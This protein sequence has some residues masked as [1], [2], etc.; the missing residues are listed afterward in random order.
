[1]DELSRPKQLVPLGAIKHRTHQTLLALFDRAEPTPP[2]S[3]FPND[4]VARMFRQ[5]AVHDRRHLIAVYE[6]CDQAGLAPETCLAG[7]LHDIGKASLAGRNVSVIDRVRHVLRDH[8]A[9]MDQM[10]P[11]TGPELARRHAEIGAE[12]LRAVGVGERVCWLVHYH[13]DESILDE[14]LNR[15]QAIDNATP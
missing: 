12:R 10:Q 2:T 11:L 7:L 9:C 8:S 3:I 1:M 15:L 6:R 13:D 14:Q 4:Q 5:L